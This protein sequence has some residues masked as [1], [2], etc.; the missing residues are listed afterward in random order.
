MSRFVIFLVLTLMA[1]YFA[2]D[3][4]RSWRGLHVAG[5]AGERIIVGEPIYLSDGSDGRIAG[6][7]YGV[8]EAKN[9]TRD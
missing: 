6:R 2:V 5:E 9:L 3:A 8:A 1:A 4:Y 7:W